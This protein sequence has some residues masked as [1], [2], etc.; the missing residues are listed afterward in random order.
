LVFFPFKKHCPGFSGSDGFLFFSSAGLPPTLLVF[1][2][3]K[4]DGP[5]DYS[6]V[7]P[8]ALSGGRVPCDLEFDW[9][10]GLFFLTNCPGLTCKLRRTPPLLPPSFLSLMSPSVIVGTNGL[11]PWGFFLFSLAPVT[12]PCFPLLLFCVFPQAVAQI[13]GQS[14]LAWGLCPP[15]AL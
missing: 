14:S 10:S 7:C 8:A 15:P 2:T 12:L 6:L 13:K 4:A 1:L 5:H 9:L 3:I 11:A